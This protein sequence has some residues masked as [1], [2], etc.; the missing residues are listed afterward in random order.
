MDNTEELR[1]KIEQF[2]SALSKQPHESELKPTQDGKALDLP[3]DF[4]ETKLD[5]YFFGIWNTQNFKFQQIFN[6]VAGSIELVIQH[7]ITGQTITR[8]GSAAIIIQQDSGAKMQDFATTKKKNALDLGMGR[9][10]AECVKNA[11]KSLGNQFGRN[12]NRKDKD[13]YQ[14]FLTAKKLLEENRKTN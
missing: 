8:T 13:K 4:V 1:L 5:E 9:L 3:I 12:I 11:A 2:L 7:P 6:E 14:G 10:K